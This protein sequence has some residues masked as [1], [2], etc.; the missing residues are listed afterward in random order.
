MR[1]KSWTA[2]KEFDVNYTT[3][4]IQHALETYEQYQSVTKVLQVLGYPSRQT[5]YAWINQYQA[6]VEVREK[7]LYKRIKQP[8]PADHS[9]KMEALKR[10][11]EDGESI[12][13]VAGE[14][15]YTRTTIYKWYRT[16][17]QEGDLGLMRKR[18]DP[19]PREPLEQKPAAEPPDEASVEALKKQIRDHQMDVD[20]LKEAMNILKKDRGVDLKVLK[21]REKYNLV[22]A[23]ST[24]YDLKELCQRLE[25]KRSSY[26]Y[27][28]AQAK[29][30]R[31]PL[32]DIKEEIQA[33]YLDSQRSYGYRR[34]WLALRT[35]GIVISEKVIRRIQKDLGLQPKIKRKR[36]Y[37]SYGGEVSPAPENLVNRHFH[38]DQP[39]QLWLSD[40]SEFAIPA[41]KVYLSPV[42]DCW[43]GLLVSWQL[44]ERPDAQLANQS[45]LK[46]A[47]TLSG[48]ERPVLHT[49]RGL[50]Y[51]W[52][53]WIDITEQY[54]LVRSMSAKGC[55]PDNA[56]CE[57]FFGRFKNEFFYG[58]SF[59]N[60]TLETFM[61]YLD[62]CLHWYN[63]KR[64]KLAFGCSILDHRLLARA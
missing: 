40:I 54:H 36:P 30:D 45:L 21:N 61:A 44:S 38:A 10:C 18:K 27:Q 41:G 1:T 56:A 32:A 5:L 29:P 2:R 16:Y 55:S 8:G 6:S 53:G 23:L 46:A 22:H 14:I 47:R 24:R 7:Q 17:L 43:D 34:I 51:R 13:Q 52:P 57:G 26:Y 60:Y 20:I 39:N 25:L 35:K 15:G 59:H 4:Q 63:T 9:V 19:L 58:R 42:L 49:D 33:I 64:I 31:D 62:T 37:S 48:D 50:H 28:A 11:F 3:E 12:T